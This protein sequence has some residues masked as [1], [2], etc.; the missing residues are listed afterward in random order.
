MSKFNEI[1]SNLEFFLNFRTYTFHGNRSFLLFLGGRHFERPGPYPT[2]GHLGLL[3]IGATSPGCHSGVTLVPIVFRASLWRGAR[4]ALSKSITLEQQWPGSGSRYCGGLNMHNFLNVCW[5]RHV[6]CSSASTW[7]L[8]DNRVV[9]N[10][11]QISHMK[12]MEVWHY[13][14]FLALGAKG[15]MST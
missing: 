3:T 2:H 4:Q 8:D 11:N 14:R 15:K 6:R 7:N 13:W 1:I 10:E 12:V 5:M 9:T